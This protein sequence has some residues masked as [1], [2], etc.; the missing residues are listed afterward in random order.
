MSSRTRRVRLALFALV[1][2]ALLA[3][4]AIS[5]ATA[6]PD[7]DARRAHARE[8]YNQYLELEMQAN[9]VAEEVNGARLQLAAIEADFGANTKHLGVAKRSLSVAQ[10]RIASRLRAL[11]MGGETGGAVEVILGAQNLD[12]LLSR[13]D[14]VERLSLIHI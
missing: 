3:L 11:Y 9:R 12:D 4:G 13:L 8:V 10:T 1:A 14:M 5:T 2:T 6:N 7:I